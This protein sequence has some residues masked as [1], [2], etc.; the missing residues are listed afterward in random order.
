[1]STSSFVGAAPL[2]IGGSVGGEFPFAH[3]DKQ[4][5]GISAEGFYRVDPFELRFHY[6]DIEIETY[7]VLLAM[8]KFFS[9]GIVRPYAEGAIG[10][11]IVNTE[12]DGLSYGVRPEVT[13]GAD[14]ALNSH[15]ST[16]ATV[17]YFGNIH[18]GDTGSGKM[19]A[20]HGVSLLGNIV[21]WF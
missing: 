6:A 17:R 21:V 12:P 14:I 3:G 11:L 19:E 10:P 16:G 8:K 20:N 5:P 2:A 9:N 15:F 13:L 1:M 18:F 4:G 7:S